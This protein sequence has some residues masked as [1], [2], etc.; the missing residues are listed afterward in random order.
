MCHCGGFRG[1]SAAGSGGGREVGSFHFCDGGVPG[2]GQC[3]TDGGK[4]LQ[5]HIPPHCRWF[6][7]SLALMSPLTVVYLRFFK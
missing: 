3:H 2:A 6:I 5:C 1:K 4:D 7:C